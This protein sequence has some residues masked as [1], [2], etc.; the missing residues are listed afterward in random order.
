MPIR[1]LCREE[2]KRG[3]LYLEEFKRFVFFQVLNIQIFSILNIYLCC[4][5]NILKKEKYIILYI[6]IHATDSD[7][8]RWYMWCSHQ[9]PLVD[10]NPIFFPLALVRDVVI[11]DRFPVLH[12][13]IRW[14]IRCSHPIEHFNLVFIPISLYNFLRNTVWKLVS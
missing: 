4:G 5:T 13:V 1:T 6:M 2:S 3:F 11:V 7:L 10:D 14:H 8:L 12:Y 9:S